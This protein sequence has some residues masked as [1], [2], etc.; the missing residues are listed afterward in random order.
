MQ[1]SPGL[2]GV[3]GGPFHIHNSQVERMM[4]QE[5]GFDYNS[6]RVAG[7]DWWRIN[8]TASQDLSELWSMLAHCLLLLSLW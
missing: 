4:K 7:G 8:C 2:E 3:L 5:P 6:R 1:T